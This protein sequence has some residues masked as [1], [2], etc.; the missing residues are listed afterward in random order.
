MT[1]FLHW[2]AP[3]FHTSF[4][5]IFSTIFYTDASGAPFQPRWRLR[6]YLSPQI[7]CGMPP[8]PLYSPFTQ[9]YCSEWMAKIDHQ[10]MELSL[11]Q[12]LNLSC[13]QRPHSPV[14]RVPTPSSCCMP[15]LQSYFLPNQLPFPFSINEIGHQLM[16]FSLSQLLNLSCWQCSHSP[17]LRVPTPSSCSML[18]LQSYYLPNQLPFPFSM[19]ETVYQ[20]MELSLSQSHKLSCWQ[21]SL[22]GATRSPTI[23]FTWQSINHIP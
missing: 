12:L 7:S 20:L 1:V 21:H 19:N 16:E 8:L 15:P 10:L 2:V 5:V 18:P 4:Y 23:C 14:L 9:L 11:S 17:V 3:F 22:P 13:W 6:R